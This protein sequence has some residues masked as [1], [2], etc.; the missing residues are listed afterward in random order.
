MGRFAACG[1]SPFGSSL[2]SKHARGQAK[3]TCTT[4]EILLSLHKSSQSL[5]TIDFLSCSTGHAEKK[6]DRSDVA[7]VSLR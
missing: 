2:S 5:Y 3:S 1:T 7:N 6:Q 4:L